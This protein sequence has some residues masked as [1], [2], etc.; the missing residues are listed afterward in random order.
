[1]HRIFE[2]GILTIF[3]YLDEDM[4]RLELLTLHLVLGAHKS[5]AAAE[6]EDSNQI[7]SQKEVGFSP[8][9]TMG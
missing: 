4:W 6:S 9:V 2:R 7:Y 8:S 3:L 5:I 1:M